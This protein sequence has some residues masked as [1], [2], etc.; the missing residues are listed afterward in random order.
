MVTTFPKG[1]KTMDNFTN[2]IK[3]VKISS[4]RQINIPKDFYEAL[5]LGDEALVEFTGKEIIIRPVMEEIVDF[6]T[7][8][9]TDLVKQG[10]SGENLIREFTRIKSAIPKALET[11]K[12]EVVAGSLV[13]ENLEDYLDST[14]DE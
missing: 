12:N 9:L 11:M 4:Q 5:D 14:E 1:R 13:N 7:D 8:I 2:K 6:S 3:R 10:Y